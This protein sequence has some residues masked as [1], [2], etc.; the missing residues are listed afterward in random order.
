MILR[1]GWFLLSSFKTRLSPRHVSRR[2]PLPVNI[3]GASIIPTSK[4]ARIPITKTIISTEAIFTMVESPRAFANRFN[5]KNVM[6]MASIKII[7]TIKIT[8]GVK[9]D[10]GPV[11]SRKKFIFGE[12]LLYSQPVL[13][14]SFVL[15]YIYF[16]TTCSLITFNAPPFLNQSICDWLY[17]WFNLTSSFEPSLW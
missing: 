11:I 8:R 13:Y 14:G 1:Q 16:L 3:S 10:K 4:S 5:L 15:L 17:V 2:S 6:T 7:K 9:K 12:S